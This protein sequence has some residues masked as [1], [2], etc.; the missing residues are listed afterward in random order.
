[1]GKY[2]RYALTTTES[3]ACAL[4]AYTHLT[5]QV[6]KSG[7]HHIYLALLFF[8]NV[9][10]YTN[11]MN[12]SLIATHHFFIASSPHQYNDNEHNELCL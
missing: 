11:I 8:L 3:I 6:S 4:H 9:L 7:I 1:M 10:F 12:R 2:Y 5:M